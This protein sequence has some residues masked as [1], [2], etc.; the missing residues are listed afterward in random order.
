MKNLKQIKEEYAIVYCRYPSWEDFINNIA[1]HEVE[2]HMNEIAKR[3]A[4]GCVKE[5]LKNAS[6]GFTPKRQEV[7][8]K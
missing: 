1:R 6:K 3:Y 2:D 7:T 5:A 8:T 4:D